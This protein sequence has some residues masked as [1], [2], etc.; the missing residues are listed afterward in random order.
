MK[1]GTRIAWWLCFA[2]FLVIGAGLIWIFSQPFAQAKALID[3]LSPDKQAESFSAAFFAAWSVPLH[4][5]GW[6]CL[7]ISILLMVFRRSA[8]TWIARW[9]A[10]LG[11]GLL[12]LSRDGKS[13]LWELRLDRRGAALTLIVMAVAAAGSAPFLWRAMGHDE[14]YTLVA[15]A[16]QPFHLAL[17]DYHLPNNHLFHTFWLYFSYR[18]FGVE[19]WA[20][21]LPAFLA[22]LALIPAVYAVGK[23]FYSWQSGLL[24][25]AMVASSSEVLWYTTVARGYTL[26]A[27]MGLFLCLASM[28]VKGHRNSAAWLIWAVCASLGFYT[29]PVFLYPFGIFSVW[30]FLSMLVNDIQGY[31]SR[32]EFLGYFLASGLLTGVL[33]FFLYLP[34]FLHHG[35]TQVL[36]GNVF[37]ESLPWPDFI[38]TAPVRL[39]EMWNSW[40]KGTPPAVVAVVVV[41][42]ILS[43]LLH[44][45]ISRAR[46]PIQLAGFAWLVPLVLLQ[47]HQLW[48]KTWFFLLPLTLIWS[49]GGLVGLLDWI[50]ARFRVRPGLLT[51]LTLVTVGLSL[52]GGCQ[53][54]RV[55]MTDEHIPD[56]PE[57]L[58]IY[59]K[60]HL[61][62]GDVLAVIDPDDAPIWYYLELHGVPRQV[63]ELKDVPFQRI[64]I[65]VNRANNQTI[66]Q[67]LKKRG[68][69]S[70]RVKIE[71]A[72]PVISMAQYTLYLAPAR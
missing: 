15:F 39:T 17:A 16:E 71:E 19:P 2:G 30:L 35:T 61:V 57:K 22:G 45:R 68:V 1:V 48:A 32:I 44:W 28:Y 41:G 18:L 59:L 33:T 49:A 3:S 10:L 27:L 5:G 25:A 31:R 46:I 60:D 4:L 70:S 51:I 13:L 8:Y 29:I 55:L 56:S 36:F 37:L 21:R 38:Q 20:V 7:A 52:V 72:E 58:T 69:E 9:G 66:Q 11:R 24:A 64:Y 12:R 62:A 34:V 42:V 47:R 63:I 43:I 14:A 53:L 6:V 54:K 65:L 26:L 40:T 23:R 67:V 50:L